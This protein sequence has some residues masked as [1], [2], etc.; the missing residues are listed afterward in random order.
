[1]QSM[2]APQVQV[3]DI[4]SGVQGNEEATNIAVI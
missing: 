1:M 3:V 4:Q 2:P